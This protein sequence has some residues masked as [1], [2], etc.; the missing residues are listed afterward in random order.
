M[1][2]IESAQK[3][4]WEEAGVE[5]IVRG[6]SLGTYENEKWGGVCQI[7]VDAMKVKAVHDTWPE[8]DRIREWVDIETAAERVREAELE[9]MIL[10]LPVVVRKNF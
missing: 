7:A 5:G 2:P 3:E 6:E 10:A 1:T 9:A 8:D 4:A